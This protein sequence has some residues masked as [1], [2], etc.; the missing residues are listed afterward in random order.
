M[1][2]FR[3]LLLGAALVH[4]LQSPAPGVGAP[5]KRRPNVVLIVA[6]DLG[7]ADVGFQ[8]ISRD[9]KTPHLD[10][11]A[12]AGVRF[13]NG[14]VSGSL[15]SPTRAGMLTGRYQQRFGFEYNDGPQS[16]DK[17]GLPVDQVTLAQTLKEA[18]YAT[19]M[20][21]KWH[22]GQRPGMHPMQRGFDT[23]FGFMAGA[24]GYTGVGQGPN[25][26]QRGTEPVE[27]V[28]YLTDMFTR[29]AVEFI[30]RQATA[31]KPFFF[32]L[33]Y[34]AVHTPLQAPPQ[35]LERFANVPDEKRRT[36]LAMLSALD[37]GVGQ[38]LGKL[39]EHH[40]EEDTLVLFLSD[41]GAP[42]LGNGSLNTPLR[43]VKNTMWEGGVHVPM[44]VQWKGTLPAG[45]VYDQPVIQLDFMP[46]VL[47]AVGAPSP[48]GVQL[49]GVD[50]RPFVTGKNTAA[51]HDALYWRYDEQW[52][53][54]S[55]NYKLV[56]ADTTRP[57][58]LFDLS[59]DQGESTDLAARQPEIAQKLQAKY[60]Q[61]NKSLPEPLW[62]DLPEARAGA[63]RAR[64]LA[65]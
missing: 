51:P 50:L 60:D 30:D 26:V 21:G 20:A 46:T 10:S 61:W 14:Y 4:L 1:S 63:R 44:A 29:E 25:A 42:T 32:Y 15:C 56:H 36:I 49:D 12:A 64:E 55:G 17:F 11:I 59:K 16:R 65:P 3:L 9:V 38:V 2:V 13:T 39:R 37:D 31:Q 22:L 52:A 35:Y 24:H 8:G 40:L 19:G 7:Y 34:N 27:K 45:K 5:A 6:D 43:G 58:M 54:R 62:R 18:G 57:P 48:K 41:N 47:A 33:A 23:F 28:D 53:I